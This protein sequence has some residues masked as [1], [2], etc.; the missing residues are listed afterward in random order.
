MGSQSWT[1]GQLAGTARGFQLGA[2]LVALVENLGAKLPGCKTP[3]NLGAPLGSPACPQPPQ[4]FPGSLRG[5]QLH[6]A[7]TCSAGMCL[8]AG[9]GRAY[10]GKSHHTCLALGKKESRGADVAHSF[11]QRVSKSTLYLAQVV[12]SIREGDGGTRLHKVC[13]ENFP[14]QTSQKAEG[15]R[16]ESTY[17]H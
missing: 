10:A 3:T 8:S 17:S 2:K 16:R 7:G 12:F 1:T 9:A 15:R 11:N 14:G 6:P 5:S 13:K 4:A